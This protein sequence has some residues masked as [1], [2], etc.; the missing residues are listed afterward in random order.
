E[1][2]GSMVAAVRY[3]APPLHGRAADDISGALAEM[4]GRMYGNHGAKAAIEIAL[5]DLV[6]RATARPAYALLGEKRRSRMAVLGVIGTGNLTSDLGE[7]EAKRAQG[8]RSYKIKVG[9]DQPAVDAE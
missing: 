6:G 8:Y 1:T 3:L 5:H 2:I 9:V 4:H 7:A